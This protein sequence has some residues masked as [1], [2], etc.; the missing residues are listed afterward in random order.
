MTRHFGLALLAS[1]SLVACEPTGNPP[2]QT[3]ADNEVM[4][5]TESYKEFG[6]YVVHFNALTTDQLDAT[7]AGEYGIVRSQNRVLLNISILKR[8]GLGLD[9]PVT[10]TVTATAA[11][12][13]GQLRNLLVR[14]IREGDAIYY[15]AET[16][17][18]NSESLIFTVN[19]TPESTSTPLTVRFQ[20][21]FFVDQ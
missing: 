2:G 7:I 12:L 14:E 3:D 5:G 1:L 9:K 20:K 15:I 18:V 10:G 4:P 6:E 11:N 17:I 21:Q 8:E 16:Q 19:A 13:T